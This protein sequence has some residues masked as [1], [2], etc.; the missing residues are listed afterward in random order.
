[1]EFTLYARSSCT[2]CETM[3]AELRPFIR[4]YNLTIRRQYID[5]DPGLEREYGARVPVLSVNGTAICEYF[6]DPDLLLNAIG[7]QHQR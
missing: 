6:L 5:N 3:E 4:K 2:L 1:M 7:K